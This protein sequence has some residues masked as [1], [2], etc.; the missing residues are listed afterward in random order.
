MDIMKCLISK[1]HYC[2]LSGGLHPIDNH[3]DCTIASYFKNNNQIK[4]SC[5]ISVNNIA[6]NFIVQLNLNQH[7][8]AVIKRS[9][10][11]CRCPQNTENNIVLP[12]LTKINHSEGCTI[13]STDFIIPALSSFSFKLPTTLWGY[14]LDTF[15]NKSDP[16]TLINSKLC[17]ILDFMT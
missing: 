3:T 12:L 4:S 7:L 13:Y 8:L 16:L 14:Q 17:L 1:G 10:I 6:S 5:P 15:L 9:S 11:E 2:S